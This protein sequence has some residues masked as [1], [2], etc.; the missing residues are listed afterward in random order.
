MKSKKKKLLINI[1]IL[2]IILIMLLIF[3]NYLY[4]D[5]VTDYNDYSKLKLNNY[6]LVFLD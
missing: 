4:K 2:S 1:S 3:F 5:D 6:N